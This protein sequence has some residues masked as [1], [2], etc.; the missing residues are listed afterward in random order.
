[1]SFNFIIL[2]HVRVIS[3]QKK[4]TAKSY[5]VDSIGPPCSRTCMHS[6]KIVK[7]VKNLIL[8]KKFCF[9][10]LDSTYFLDS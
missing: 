7:I 4:T 2:R 9:I 10:I 1:M 3:C 5:N 6:V 8:V